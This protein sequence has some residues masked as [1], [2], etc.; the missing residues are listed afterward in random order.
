MRRQLIIG[1]FLAPVLM[2]TF[3]GVKNLFK[4]GVT[5]TDEERS[6][7]LQELNY[8]E[9]HASQEVSQL[10]FHVDEG[11]GLVEKKLADFKG[12]TTVVHIWATWC[13]PCQK[14]MPLFDKFADTYGSKY[15]VIG[16]S[17]DMA[18]K[19]EEAHKTVKDFCKENGYTNFKLGLDHTVSIAKDFKVIGV[20]TTIFINKEG[21][22]MGRVN[23]IIH[24]NDP[25]VAKVIE[26]LLA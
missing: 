17:V 10:A 11:R 14:E 8:T 13:G 12:K 4:P 25:K 24:W 9:S 26:S 19:V 15:N 3:L 16:L 23:G 7:I 20:P 2:V 5:V 22:E 6:D 21:K 1:M 18:D